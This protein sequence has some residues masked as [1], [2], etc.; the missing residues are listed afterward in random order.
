VQVVQCNDRTP[1]VVNTILCVPTCAVTRRT[2][3]AASYTSRRGTLQSKPLEYP[4]NAGTISGHTLWERS[5]P[6]NLYVLVCGN[7]SAGVPTL[8][9]RGCARRNAKKSRRSPT[10]PLAP[11]E[12]ERL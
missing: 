10:L 1:R 2:L 9:E 3:R 8:Y 11:L 6:I 4:A 7:E 5:R 12:S